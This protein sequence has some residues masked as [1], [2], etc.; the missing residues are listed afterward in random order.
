MP[1]DRP[2]WR[3]RLLSLS[4]SPLVKRAAPFLA[5]AAAL[6]AVW[7]YGGVLDAVYPVKDWL[8]WR[9]A[10]LWFYSF[11]LS[12]ACTSLGFLVISR[13]VGER[14]PVVE[15]LV[16]SMAAGLVCFVLLMYAGGALGWYHLWFA[17]AL[18][19]VMTA[20]GGPSLWRYARRNI[21]EWRAQAPERRPLARFITVATLI[22]G[23]LCVALVYL[24][25][26]TPRA[27]NFDAAWYHLPVA[28][29]YALHGR[30]VPFVGD[31]E[32]NFP[33][34]DSLVHTWGWL[35][36]VPYLTQRWT[37]P[38][39]GEF[40]IFLWTLAGV[41]AMVQFLLDDTRVKGTWVAFFLFP[42]IFVYDSNLAGASDHFLA[43]FGP[44]L[45][46]AIARAIRRFDLRWCMLA[47]LFT[48]GAV[49]TKYQALYPVSGVG[50]V[51][52]L[53][54]L[55]HAGRRL[56]AR[57]R[58]GP[59]DGAAPLVSWRALLVAP[60][61]VAGVGLL[62]SSPHF[63]KNW[64]FYRDPLY[65]FAQNFF[66]HATPS[67]PHAAWDLKWLLEDPRWVPHGDLWH[68]LRT[69]FEILGTFSFKPHY[70]FTRNW[71]SVGG[72]FTFSLP[73]L[74]F[75]RRPRWRLW[76]GA[77]AAAGGVLAWA[78]VFRV[79]RYLQSVMPLLA[80]ATAA[81][82]IRAWELGWPA[83][84]ALVPLV[85][86]QVVW[87]GDAMFYTQKPRLDDA[88]QLITSGYN[89]KQHGERIEYRRAFREIDR[90]LP[91]GS[92]TILHYLRRNLGIRHEVWLD[93]PG[94]QGMVDYEGL[95]GPRELYDYYK[96]LHVTHLLHIPGARTAWA[97]HD[98]ILFNALVYRYGVNK[99]RFGSYQL[100]QL[101]AKPPPPDKLPWYVLSLGLGY[102][103][104]LYRVERMQTYEI[105][106]RR[107][108]HFPLPDQPIDRSNA[109]L[110]RLFGEAQAV[111]V[112]RR[113]R[114]SATERTLLGRDFVLI[115]R[116]RDHRTYLRRR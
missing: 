51:F 64:V 80:A 42:A 112:G 7:T 99:R 98:G 116:Y 77:L 23:V 17:I 30:I 91:Q 87:G 11:V 33:Q 72:L 9:I 4:S 109:G 114:I 15:T 55:W 1:E 93:M 68:R 97:K 73:L 65:P 60:L 26:L 105:L 90:A 36:P 12:V 74:L 81:I 13:T 25:L 108:Q 37:L 84:A 107:M 38:L 54:W 67:P 43:F 78:L 5:A 19:L 21:E 45:F 106:P 61:V 101:P 8:F 22:F 47:G 89:G 29:D 103:D 94:Q 28:Q 32:R 48:A 111:V 69:S 39:H 82:L 16:H 100:V 76:L 62:V 3:E 57:F 86:L 115:A 58:A 50:L 59:P 110:S 10:L 27:I 49:L 44:P 6:W 95:R 52:V 35:L 79:D 56:R 92:R 31:Y 85:L 71:P 40:S 18:P 41:A 14:L 113:H 96:R 75:V 63:I 2:S 20:A 102:H 70:S 24:P 104:G 88:M 34:L 66:K 83:R 46:L 53:G